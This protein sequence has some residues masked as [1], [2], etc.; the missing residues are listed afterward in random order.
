ML[1]MSAKE[2]SFGCRHHF[3][4]QPPTGNG[5]GEDIVFLL[6]MMDGR[7]VGEW[8]RFVDYNININCP[9]TG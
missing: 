5:C 1:E 9:T 4:S 8:E 6:M 2:S 7:M 3:T